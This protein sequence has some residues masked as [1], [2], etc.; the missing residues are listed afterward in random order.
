MAAVHGYAI[1]CNGHSFKTPAGSDFVV[2]TKALG[3]ALLAEWYAQTD[4]INPAMMPMNQLASTALDIVARDRASIINQLAAYATTELLCHRVELPIDLA[5]Q[6]AKIWQPLLD[7]SAQQFMASL[8]TT[9]GLMPVAQPTA[10]LAALRGAIEACDDFS[11]AGLRQAVD[12]SGSLILGLALMV[13]KLEATTVIQ[14]S[15]LH[16]DFQAIKWGTDPALEALRAK[17]LVD[18]EACQKWFSLLRAV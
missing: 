14:A 17:K 10:S 6:E 3:E 12:V 5:A 15:E 2:P 9:V 4:K 8:Q 7:W 18:L 11:L 13:Q 1:M 16:A